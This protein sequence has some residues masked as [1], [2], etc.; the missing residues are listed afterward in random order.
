MWF[1]YILYSEKDGNLYVGCSENLNER[2]KKHKSGTVHSTRNRR[3]LVLIHYEKFP[4]KKEAFARERF[5][6][7]LWAGRFK[8]KIKQKYIRSTRL[9][10]LIA[11]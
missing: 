6:K 2:V 7:S 8:K 5:L 3:P 1:I 10:E 11:S 9:H 4:E